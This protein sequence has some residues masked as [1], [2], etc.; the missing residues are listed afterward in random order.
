LKSASHLCQSLLD[1]KHD[2]LKSIPQTADYLRI[3]SDLDLQAAVWVE[4]IIAA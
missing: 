1:E 3:L 4:R 2:Y